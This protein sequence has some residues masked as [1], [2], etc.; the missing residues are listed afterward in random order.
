MLPKNLWPCHDSL[1]HFKTLRALHDQWGWWNWHPEPLKWDQC[2]PKNMLWFAQISPIVANQLLRSAHW[3]CCISRLTVICVIWIYISRYATT[4]IIITK[5][6]S[7][8]GHQ[9]AWPCYIDGHQWNYGS[10]FWWY[11]K[12]NTLSIKQRDHRKCKSRH[13]HLLGDLG[14]TIHFE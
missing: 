8:I 5:Y 10:H 11:N 4:T 6:S 2:L 13:F 14:N 3:D 1:E 12:E 7:C 9:V